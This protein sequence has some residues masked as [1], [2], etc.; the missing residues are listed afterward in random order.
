MT[1]LE[2]YGKEDAPTMAQM[3]AYIASPLWEDLN[4]YLQ[5]AYSAAPQQAFSGCSGQPGW[6]VKYV[7]GGKALCTLYPMKGYFTALVVVGEKER[8]EVELQLPTYTQYVQ[9]VHARA[10]SLMGAKWLMID[11]KDEGTL[12]D[13]KRLIG[14]RRA[15]KAAA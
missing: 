2:T 5:A 11:V 6:N 15:P 4:A 14:V 10:G 12:A 3:T 13:V 7:K 9:G 8:T 1:W